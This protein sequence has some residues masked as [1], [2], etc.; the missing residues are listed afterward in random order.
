LKKEKG[1]IMRTRSQKRNDP[2]RIREL[3]L[4][5]S[6]F[7]YNYNRLLFYKRLYRQCGD[8]G[9]AHF[10]FLRIVF[11]NSSETI[12]E[13]LA[14]QT[15]EFGISTLVRNAFMSLATNGLLT[16]EGEFHLHQRKLMAPS[17]QPKHVMK[18]AD[19]MVQ[20]GEEIQKQWS[21]GKVI[22]I[23]EEMTHVTMDCLGKVLFAADADFE[24]DQMG[25]AMRILLDHIDSM[26]SYPVPQFL[27][28]LL[29]GSSRVR[30]ATTLLKSKIQAMIEE[31][32]SSS[33]ERDDLLSLLLHAQA[34][35]GYRMSDAQV[36]D[37][38]MTV[39]FAGHDTL[40]QALSWAWYLL[41]THPD[42]YRRV[43]EEIDTTL[44]GRSPTYKDLALLPYTLQ[45]L[46]ESMRLYPPIHAI[47]RVARKD[48]MVGDFHV[49]PGDTV[50][51]SPY[52]VHHRP[53]YFPDP[54][55]FDP[56]RFSRENEKK[57]PRHAYMPFGAGP[58]ICIGM[59]FA[60]MEGH[61]L[62]ATL[63]QRVSFELV[64]GQQGIPD[65]K[66]TLQPRKRMQV[67]VHRR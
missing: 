19:V 56:E 44:Q 26:L 66:V 9:I 27:Q 14:E 63:V 3:P 4:V 55:V 5:G 10:G 48:V 2:P 57:L 41:L 33:E 58:R 1:T 37:E 61:L 15:H 17:L 43:Q 7:L 64:S 8:A 23:A 32:R 53:D 6:T 24:A 40:T 52:I 50:L 42:A 18:Y 54:E 13:V 67:R 59:H 31:R 29:P 65:P 21:D 12:K 39:L 22:D 45:V 36:Y 47:V 11:F 35:D 49:R 25:T 38:I 28:V 51:I 62:L 34:E 46:K 30:K 20:C 60:M 16:S